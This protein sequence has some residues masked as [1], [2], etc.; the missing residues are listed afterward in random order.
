MQ[1]E[2]RELQRQADSLVNRLEAVLQ[3]KFQSSFDAD[4]PIDKTL[5]FLQGIIRVR[6]YANLASIDCLAYGVLRSLLCIAVN[7]A[8]TYTQKHGSICNC[9]LDL[10]PKD[11][12]FASGIAASLT[13]LAQSKLKLQTA[14]LEKLYCGFVQG[15]VPPVQSAQYFSYLWH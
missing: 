3:D 6:C 11:T 9:F 2:K 4:T 14:V 13:G 5:S 10:I 1:M 7:I 12:W 8:H 15:V